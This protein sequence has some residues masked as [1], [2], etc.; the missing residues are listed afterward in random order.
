MPSLSRVHVRGGTELNAALRDR[1]HWCKA[2]GT[3]ELGS[4]ATKGGD[5][6]GT[7]HAHDMRAHSPHPEQ[8]AGLGPGPGAIVPGVKTAVAGFS[9]SPHC[10]TQAGGSDSKGHLCRS[11]ALSARRVFPSPLVSSPRPNGTTGHVEAAGTP[12]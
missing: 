9:A 3:T 7:V 1:G 11:L 2:G 12:G 4:R 10:A 6:A 5:S 8:G